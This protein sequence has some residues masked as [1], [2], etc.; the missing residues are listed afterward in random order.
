VSAPE[1][2]RP[3]GE[4]LA[5]PRQPELIRRWVEAYRASPVRMPHPVDVAE[6]ARL[7][8]PILEGLSDALRPGR[9]PA[10]GSSP[11]PASALVPG[12]NLARETEKAASLV[13]A[14]LAAGGASG[15]DLTALWDGLRAVLA[16]TPI[17]A[18]DREP[19]GRFLDWLAA[20]ALDA[21]ATALVLRERERTREQLEDGTPVVSIVPELPAAFL[22]GRSDGVLVDAVL[23]RL[24]LQIVRVGARAGIIDVTGLGDPHRE[25]VLE[26]VRRFIG[27]RKIAGSVSLVVVGLPGDAEPAWR[28]LGEEVGAPLWFEAHFDRA[29]ERGL[30]AAG[31]RLVR[32]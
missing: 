30:A 31:V 10:T 12:S 15:F 23:S 21:F 25:E 19:L 2:A 6:M 22:I 11:L 14:L 16:A 20:V 27:H 18:E 29:V 1:Q 32:S 13:G 9:A 17:A 24:L 5:A 26:A 8:A 3:A 7:V 4:A 28:A